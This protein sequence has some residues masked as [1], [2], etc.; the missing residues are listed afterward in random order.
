[1]TAVSTRSPAPLTGPLFA[2][3]EIDVD[4][5][6]DGS[7][8]LRS[9]TPLGPAPR[10]LGCMLARWAQERPSAPFLAERSAGGEW[11][12][13]SFGEAWT[14]SRAIGQAFVDRALGPDRAVVALSGNSIDHALVMLAC[15]LT[16]VPFAPV[17]TAYSLISTDFAK[18]RHIAALI[19]PAVVFVDRIGPYARALEVAGLDHAE[20]VSSAGDP[21]ATP[22][23]QLAA[24]AVDASFEAAA[25]AVGPDTVAKILFT[26]GSTGLPKGVLT[27]HRMLCT[28]QE[29]L[30][31]VWPFV[32]EEPPVLVDWLP[33][34]HTF[35]GSNNT[36]LVL[37]AGG[38]L[39]IDAGK[40]LPGL[41]DVTVQNLREV[42]PTVYYNV[43]RGFS[44]LLPFLEGDQQLAAT[45][46]ARLRV[47]VYAGAALT[48]EMWRRLEELAR[49]TA[50][51][52]VPMTSAW[53]STETAP[54]ATI[55]HFTSDGPG[56]I[57]V[58][59]PGVEVKL[60]P[61]GAK[62]ELRV[63]GPNVMPGYLHDP[64]RTAAAFDDEGFYRIGDAGRP[65]DPDDPSAGIVFDGR[66]AEDFKLST[67]TW[68]SVAAVRTALV[69]AVAPLLTDAVIAGHDRDEVCVLAW[70][71]PGAV[72]RVLGC[73]GTPG[74]LAHDPK[75]H[76]FVTSA[77]RQ[78][79]DNRP[80]SSER[81]ARV[82][83]LPEPPSIDANEVTDKGYI[84]QRAV[85][86]HRAGLVE[87]LYANPPGDAV[88]VM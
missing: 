82:L 4:R 58:P 56:N 54:M 81:V 37:N 13:V 23:D 32:D 8:V 67:G 53:G 88:L 74:E 20:L 19:Q 78:Y 49:R 61:N 86:E 34:S 73:Q 18:L 15:H 43:P 62:L 14:S 84:N 71:D 72:A 16:G 46:F 55:A 10:N 22:I 3:P 11:R 17:S 2:K 52:I 80:G 87:H 59:V 31:Q 57:G 35:G 6:D 21:A 68:V 75:V 48:P 9:R 42:S 33:W 63:R 25:T 64:E 44:A 24:T 27:T 69:S 45:F 70:V 36:G 83:L 29:M 50:G 41:I 79:N 39:Y 40:P 66:I 65:V 5:R 30:R 7:Y 60:T 1:V 51:R 38:T 77:I 12:I 47:I 76:A 85:L 28:N 26:S